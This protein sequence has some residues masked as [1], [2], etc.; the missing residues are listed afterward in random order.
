MKILTLWVRRY[1]KLVDLLRTMPKDN[2]E[3]VKTNQKARLRIREK[4]QF[5]S[6]GTVNIQ[7]LG[8]GARGTSS[9][10]YIFSEQSR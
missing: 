2:S 1:S 5:F 7:V 4:S 10:V 6:P 8:S 3:H 9:S